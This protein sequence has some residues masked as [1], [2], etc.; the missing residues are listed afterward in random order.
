MSHRGDIGRS[1]HLLG[2][3]RI[4]GDVGEQILGG[5]VGRSRDL[6]GDLHHGHLPRIDFTPR[7]NWPEPR[8]AR[9][10]ASRQ[11]QVMPIT[12]ISTGVF[13][14]EHIAMGSRGRAIGANSAST[15]AGSLRLVVSS[16]PIP[17]GAGGLPKLLE[18]Q[19]CMVT[20][21]NI[22]AYRG[23]IREK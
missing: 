12:F 15:P 6:P 1:R 20:Q 22:H 16:A 11:F 2:D 4:G 14:G 17:G 3:H 13:L 18:R 9:G 7:R 21:C 19:S 8:P 5:D 10:S 23:M